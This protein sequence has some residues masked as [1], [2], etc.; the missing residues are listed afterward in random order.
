MLSRPKRRNRLALGLASAAFALVANAASPPADQ[1]SSIAASLAGTVLRQTYGLPPLALSL[2]TESYT[3]PAQ[4]E[5]F[6][7]TVATKAED[8]HSGSDE[9]GEVYVQFVRGRLSSVQWL[10]ER[11]PPVAAPAATRERVLQWARAT[12][13]LGRLISE[14][15]KPSTIPTQHL[16]LASRDGSANVILVLDRKYGFLHRAYRE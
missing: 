2:R 14:T 11:E 8:C 15:D 5:R 12:F 16:E 6:W 13:D 4:P 7:I 9:I 10:S 1:A 3:P